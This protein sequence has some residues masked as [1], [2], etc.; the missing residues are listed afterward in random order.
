MVTANVKDELIKNY[1]E[2]VRDLIDNAQGDYD[3][4]AA[5]SSDDATKAKEI[6]TKVHKAMIARVPST[7]EL[8]KVSLYV[9]CT[10]TE[11]SDEISLV[12]ITLGN[13]VTASKK[14]KFGTA[15][16]QGNATQKVYDFMMGV[17]QVLL[18]D[19]LIEENLSRVNE[20]LHDATTAA[21]CNFSVKVV[22]PLGYE[23]KK[24]ARISDDEVCFVVD[25]ARA[26]ALED[27]LVL[28]EGATDLVDED[29]IKAHFNRLVEEFEGIQST[30]QLV[31]IYGGALVAH[32]CDLSKR[33]KPIT[34][35]KKVS[36]K[37]VANVKGNSATTAYYSKD[38]VYALV[39]RTEGSPWEIVLSPFNTDTL[40][41][42]D[43]DILAEVN[44]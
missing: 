21:N 1:E 2:Q 5:M 13:K 9:N 16:T 19:G 25:E 35:I 22:S 4:D 28:L 32:V 34:M 15:I 24:I 33:V 17:Y 29:T 27:I 20:V 41:T 14:F 38:N 31:S 37:N 40:V 44:K 36:S 10:G 8:P 7:V 39:G 11:G 12:N 26:F 6:V 3:L 30:V 42:V 18:V 43:D 23:G